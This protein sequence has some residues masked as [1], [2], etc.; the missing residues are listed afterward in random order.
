MTRIKNLI[1]ISAFS[2]LI[3]GLPAIASAQWPSG[4]YGGGYYGNY[5]IRSTVRN[6]HNRAKSFERSVDRYDGRYNDR[7]SRGG[8]G[9]WQNTSYND[10]LEILADRFEKASDDLR[11]AYGN[12]RNLRNSADEAR[13]VLEIGSRIDRMIGSSRGGGY[14]QNQWGAIRQ[15]LRVISDAYGFNSGRNRRDRGGWGGSDWFP[16]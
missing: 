7:R 11:R 13:R 5:D 16:F 4:G 9:G 2:L 6:L 14:L 1:A 3:L 8:W 10:S 12:G 15:D